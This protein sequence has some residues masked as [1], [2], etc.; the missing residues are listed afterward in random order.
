MQRRLAEEF[1]RRAWSYDLA[2]VPTILD[3][4]E[5]SGT[6]DAEKLAANVPGEFLART[7]ATRAEIA[8]A[9][10]RA[11]GGKTLEAEPESSTTLII[12]NHS[13]N[14]GPG[15]SVSGGNLNTGRQIIVQSGSDK[16]DILEA[17]AALVG[18]GLQGEWSA[19]AASELAQVIDSRADIAVDDVVEA[20]SRA[21]KDADADPGRIKALLT[22]IATGAVS[23][24]LGTG[25]TAGLGS[26]L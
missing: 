18:S 24:A 14:L 16:S 9:I 5:R 1:E 21:A 4:V 12:N 3:E 15:A 26:L 13:I 11:I 19:Q 2:T 23:G 22:Q 7:G 6:G 17:V 10:K 20:S 8:D 25:I